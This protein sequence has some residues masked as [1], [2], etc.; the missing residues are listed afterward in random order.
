MARKHRGIRLDHRLRQAGEQAV[1]RRERR[2][3]LEHRPEPALGQPVLARQEHAPKLGAVQ[4]TAAHLGMRD[5]RLPADQCAGRQGSR[6]AE[7]STPRKR[8]LRAR[9]AE[10]SDPENP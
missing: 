7:K 9:S 5:A 10:P 8:T 2:K 3:P 6:P 1:G 4:A